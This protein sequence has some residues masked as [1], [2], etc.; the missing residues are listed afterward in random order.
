MKHLFCCDEI[1]SIVLSSFQDSLRRDLTNGH[2]ITIE[3]AKV[4]RSIYI[5]KARNKEFWFG[6]LVGWFLPVEKKSFRPFELHEII[7]ILVNIS[8]Q[9][10]QEILQ[11]AD[12]FLLPPPPLPKD[13]SVG[14]APLYLRG[15]CHSFRACDSASLPRS[16]RSRSIDETIALGKPSQL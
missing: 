13:D 7:R 3:E 11:S 8:G 10:N 1:F 14:A 16:P 5:P 15:A 2:G 6:F 4:E 9:G 12:G